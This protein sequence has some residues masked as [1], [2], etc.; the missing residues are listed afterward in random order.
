MTLRL[1]AFGDPLWREAVM[2]AMEWC[3]QVWNALTDPAHAFCSTRELV[4]AWNTSQPDP[5]RAWHSTRGPMDRTAKSLARIRWTVL[6]PVEWCSDLRQKIHLGHHSPKMIGYMLQEAVQRLH[7]RSDATQLGTAGFGERLSC[8]IPKA[9]WRSKEGSA[10]NKHLLKAAVCQALWT[11]DRAHDGGYL[12]PSLLCPL[13]QCLDSLFHRIWKCQ[14]AGPLT[15]RMQHSSQATRALV[16]S[17]PRLLQWTTGLVPMPDVPEP[18][19]HSDII[20]KDATGQVVNLSD[21]VFNQGVVVG[22]GSASRLAIPELNRAAFAL[23]WLRAED[24]ALVYTVQGAV[25]ACFPQTSQAAENLAPA[26]A[27]DLAKD[28]WTYF[29]DCWNVIEM[30]GKPLLQQLRHNKMYSGVR[31][32]VKAQF[33]DKGFMTAVHQKAHLSDKDIAAIDDKDLTILALEIS[34]S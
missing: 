28:E 7:E 30:M 26:Q 18:S 31:R 32:F 22:D 21:V 23:A 19:I 4:D 33:G 15:M 17:D 27:S 12:P 3:R 14:A 34:T 5:S 20:V 8:A 1:V 2:A 10:Q 9:L 29:G 11:R 6:S 13:C 25:P 24:L 16:Q